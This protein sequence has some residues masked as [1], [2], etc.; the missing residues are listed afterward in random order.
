[1]SN[2]PALVAKGIAK[3]NE[4]FDGPNWVRRVSVFSLSM[5][6]CDKCILG[7]L[8]GDYETG[9]I[10]MKNLDGGSYGFA[11]SSLATSEELTKEWGQ[12]VDRMRNPLAGDKVHVTYKVD[13]KPEYYYANA[14]LS[15]Y[16]MKAAVVSDPRPDPEPG[17][18]VKHTS[19]LLNGTV[20]KGMPGG[21]VN[22]HMR[23][24]WDGGTTAHSTPS[25]SLTVL[26]A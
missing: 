25:S 7:Q 26:T 4:F 20:L 23:V 9:V 24:I 6:T 17:D 3:L 10:A 8:F 22:G 12:R 21:V 1:M 11:S 14:T 13:W 19:S 16:A 15:P 2:A 18:R 5:A